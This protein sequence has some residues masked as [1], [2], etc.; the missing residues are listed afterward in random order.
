MKQDQAMADTQ[1]DT[2]LGLRLRRAREARGMGTAAVASAL[3][4]PLAIIEAMEREDIARLGAPIYV[5][6]NYSSY[7]RLVGVPV[8]AVEVFC[9][10]LDQAPQPLAPSSHVPRS[11]ILLDRYLKRAAYIALTASIVPSVIWLASLDRQAPA[12]QTLL[13]P[14]ARSSQSAPVADGADAASGSVVQETA[15]PA[16]APEDAPL[17]PVKAALTPSYQNPPRET[18]ELA[19]T[20][21]MPADTEELILRFEQESWFEVLGSDGRRIESGIAAPGSERSF[22]AAS[23]GKVSLGN[24]GGVLVER[25][26]QRIDIAPFRRANVARFALSSDGSLLPADG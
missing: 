10:N 3:H 14:P 9:R 6:G 5:R 18:P 19:S 8:A 24:A 13:E 17:Q 12:V 20:Q 2:T 25:G 1:G 26:G 23:V 15:I 16:Q 7:A 22:P 4:L 11:R 21:P